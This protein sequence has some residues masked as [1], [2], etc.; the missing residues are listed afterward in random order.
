MICIGGV[1]DCEVDLF[2]CIVDSGYSEGV[3]FGGVSGEIVC[4]VFCYDVDI[5]VVV[6]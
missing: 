2:G 6:G 5:V 4:S 1:V 3:G